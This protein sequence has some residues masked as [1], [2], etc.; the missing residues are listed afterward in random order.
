MRL[1]IKVYNSY[2]NNIISPEEI[3]KRNFYHLR[4]LYIY[5]LTK[6]PPNR[7][8]LNYQIDTSMLSYIL[9]ILVC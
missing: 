1:L 5:K 8:L 7:N 3:P 2:Q 4:D 9:S 6:H